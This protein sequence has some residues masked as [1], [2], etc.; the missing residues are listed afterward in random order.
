MTEEATLPYHPQMAGVTRSAVRIGATS[1]A[2]LLGFTFTG[3]LV[4]RQPAFTAAPR[5]LE[6]RADESRLRSDIA[7]LTQEASP[8]DFRHPGNLEAAAVHIRSEFS[9]AGAVVSDQAYFARGQPFRNVLAR[10]G[11]EGRGALVIG[12]HYDA[13]GDT[14]ANPGADDNASGVA[15]LLEVAR[16]LGGQPLTRPLVLVAYSTEE[17]PFYHSEDMGSAVHASSITKAGLAPIGMVSL[18]MIGF[19]AATQPWPSRLFTL[20]YPTHGDFIAVVGRWADRALARD[21]RRGISGSST[22]P[23]YSYSGP[24]IAGIEASDHSSYWAVGTSAVM[25]TDTAFLRNPNYHAPTDTLE[26]LDLTRMAQVVTGV[27]NAAAN[28]CGV[29]AR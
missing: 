2:A 6:K 19:Y 14:N 12:A 26:T 24:V 1:A 20:A 29:P 13:F 23:A 4:V 25:V 16:L 9:K 28:I 7:F 10:L 3:V 18:E 8:R 5:V 11:P 27:A 15:A 21:V 17:P 22:V